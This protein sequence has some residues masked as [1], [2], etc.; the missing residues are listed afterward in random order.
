ML[1]EGNRVRREIDED[2]PIPNVAGHAIQRIILSAKPLYLLHMRR[3]LQRA[4]ELVGPG[5]IRALNSSGQRTL[6]LLAKQ[7]AAMTAHVVKGPDFPIL[8]PQND[9]VRVCN[10][11]HEVVA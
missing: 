9:D 8:V 5:V 4:V 6:L 7:R 2:M 11:P 10:S 1:G 3:I